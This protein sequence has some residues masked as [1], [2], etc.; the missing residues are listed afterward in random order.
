[1][2]SIGDHVCAV[3]IDRSGEF[4][5][6]PGRVEGIHM[7][8]GAYGN[9]IVSVDLFLD[10]GVHIHIAGEHVFNTRDEAL[11]YAEMRTK[12]HIKMLEECLKKATDEVQHAD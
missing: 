8:T 4:K 11:Q 5:L 2:T 9:V 10:I 1:M 6:K 7:T 3:D 12:E